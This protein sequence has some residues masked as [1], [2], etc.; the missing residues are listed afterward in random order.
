[1]EPTPMSLVALGRWAG[2]QPV[3]ESLTIGLSPD[4]LAFQLRLAFDPSKARDLTAIYELRL[5]DDHLMIHI[6]RG[7]IAVTRAPATNPD[8]V[9]EA[10]VAEFTA[11]ILGQRPWDDSV[12]VEGDKRAARRLARLFTRT[13][14][15]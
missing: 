6:G 5:D 9:I 15:G 13:T 14:A 8:A 7:E 1:M 3:P 10:G 4:A 12:V 11:L 2:V